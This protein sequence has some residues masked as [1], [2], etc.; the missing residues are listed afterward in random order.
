MKKWKN[1]ILST[2]FVSAFLLGSSPASL[3]ADPS[4]AITLEGALLVDGRTMLPLRTIFESIGAEVQWNQPTQTV[5]AVKGDTTITMQIHSKTAQVNNQKHELDVPAQLINNKTMVPVRFVS[6]ALGAKVT[7]NGQEGIVGISIDELQLKVFVEDPAREDELNRVR[8]FQRQRHAVAAHDDGWVYYFKTWPYN[9]FNP[10]ENGIYKEKL[11]G[12][13][14]GTG[15]VK[16]SSDEVYSLTVVDGWIYYTT[17]NERTLEGPFY[18]YKMSLDG[19]TKK[20]LLTLDFPADVTYI[21][22]DWIYYSPSSSY[23]PNDQYGTQDLYKISTDGKNK[24]FIATL[25]APSANIYNMQVVGDY[26]YYQSLFRLHRIKEDGSE[27]LTYGEE[28]IPNSSGFIVRGD[29]IYYSQAADLRK[30][31]TDGSEVVQLIP[32]WFKQQPDGSF[33]W[34]GDELYSSFE[35]FTFSVKGN[36]LYY[37]KHKQLHRYD[38][39]TGEIVQLTNEPTDILILG[40]YIYSSVSTF[41]DKPK[42]IK[43]D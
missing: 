35:V 39:T 20:R 37:L 4:S 19:K 30:A 17:F 28:I 32:G 7:W 24:T 42:L 34:E 27:K 1:V 43:I 36:D 10:S 9:Y 23:K 31:R 22:K 14:D 41:K 15:R 21:D 6:E 18:L 33:V 26:I 2:I 13:L 40:D 25:E 12:T 11:D 8:N 38:L 16:L 3:A 5:T 29:W